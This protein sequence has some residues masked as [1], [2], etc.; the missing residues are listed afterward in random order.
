MSSSR[1]SPATAVSLRGGHRL[2]TRVRLRR[3]PAPRTAP[4]PSGP[5][6][7]AP[8]AS[9]GRH[10]V[11]R[12]GPVPPAAPV[13]APGR[14][15]PRRRPDAHVP[16]APVLTGVLALLL[17][18]L[19]AAPTASADDGHG[20]DGSHE[21][22]RGDGRHGDGRHDFGY[23]ALGDSV[24]FGYRPPQVTPPADY[25]DASNFVGYPEVLAERSGLRLTN[26]SC[27]GE[28]TASLIDATAQSNGCENS[29]GLPYGYRTFY[30]LHVAYQG[31]QLD[32]AVQYLRSH[33]RTRLVS[34]DVGAN[35]LFICQATTP[36]K[37]T[38]TDFV[39]T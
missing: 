2:A 32:Y 30:P 29:V 25:L 33:P 35:D 15:L 38:G 18:V 20:D 1:I 22:Y 36:D 21:G 5:L 39:A 10:V 24:A 8:H 7:S 16:A 27:P 31:A 23:L 28:T 6:T 3:G 14:R 34:I 19:L 12:P 17:S 26:A 4:P 11:H 37:G 13:T 9:E